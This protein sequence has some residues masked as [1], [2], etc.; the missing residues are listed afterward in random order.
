MGR[1]L[2]P[3]NLSKLSKYMGKGEVNILASIRAHAPNIFWRFLRYIGTFLDHLRVLTHLWAE[4]WCPKCVQVEQI[5]GQGGCQYLSFYYGLMHQILLGGFLRHIGTLLDSLGGVDTPMDRLPAPKNLAEL[6]IYMG[7]WGGQYLSFYY[8]PI[9]Q[10]FWEVPETHRNISRP[11]GRCWHTH[12]QRAG[13]QQIVQVEQ[14]DGGGEVNISAS[15]RAH[16]PII[17]WRFLTHIETFLDHSGGVYT[18]EGRVP[19]PK[20]GLHWGNTWESGEVNI[21]ASV[22]AS[23]T[24]IVLEAPETQRNI[25]RP[26]GRC[27]HTHGQSANT[28]NFAELRKYMGGVGRSICQL[29]SETHTPN[30]FGRF[31]RDIGTFLDHLGGVDTP[32]GRVLVPPN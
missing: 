7:E 31:L 15:V 8:G 21:S 32:M 2:A 24:K 13:S 11:L 22:M 19:A 5:H 29:Q 23:C 1:G 3:N 6:S 14:I 12:G 9:H 17:F 27:W 25:S 16:A 26:L 30:S 20:T 28:Q 10:L 4:C 18:S